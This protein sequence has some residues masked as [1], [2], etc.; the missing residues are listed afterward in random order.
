MTCLPE[1]RG[2]LAWFGKIG[3]IPVAAAIV[4]QQAAQP[5]DLFRGERREAVQRRGGGFV[6]SVHRSLLEPL[7]SRR[8][9]ALVKRDRGGLVV[10]K[11]ALEL[12]QLAHQRQEAVLLLRGAVHQGRGDVLVIPVR[13]R[14]QLVAAPGAGG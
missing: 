4:D 8:A 1:F 6:F 3:G 11:R 10:E 9:A 14:R 12:R 2:N 5:L 7:L 13:G